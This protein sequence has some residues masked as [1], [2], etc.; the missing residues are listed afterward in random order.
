MLIEKDNIL[1]YYLN[2]T[3]PFKKN[4]E[5]INNNDLIIP[6]YK[7]YNNILTINY[8]LTQL[9]K[10]IKHYKIKISGNKDELKKICYNFLYYSFYINI[11]Q[12]K[13]RNNL[14]KKYNLLHGPAFIKK[15][16]CIN[17]VDFCTLD[18]IKEINIY[19]FF[20]FKDADNFIYGFD[21]QSIYNLYL[22]NSNKLENPFNTKLI[23]K[24]ILT[25]LLEIIR[26]SKILNIKLDLNYDKIDNFNEKKKLDF[27]ILELFQKID[28]L[29]NF[30]NISWFN[31]LNKYSLIIFLKELIDIWN[32]RA[33]LTLETKFNICPPFG[34]PFRNLNFN[35]RNINSYHFN[36]IKKNIINVMD[37]LINKGI[38]NEYKSL[39][40][41]YI[42]CSLTLVNNDAAE[43]LPHLYWS[44]NNN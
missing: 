19:H 6:K 4:K 8:N 10:F 11:L 37:E 18:N 2:K 26:L 31:S 12:K 34:D 43:A 30:T 24:K 39:G 25:D 36:V 32:Y 5:K 40:A 22:K 27:K 35:M 21:I 44:V 15:H 28:S 29:G 9:K 38:N 20:S 23:D 41:S 13:C 1:S 33:M 17:D 42:L 14:I 3:I 7:D 16:L